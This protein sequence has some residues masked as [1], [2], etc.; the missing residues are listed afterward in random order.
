[1][2]VTTFL[3]LQYACMV[4]VEYVCNDGHR[5]KDHTET[6]DY[7]ELEHECPNGA[8]YQITTQGA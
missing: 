3:M 8:I 1:M 4:V 5:I 6:I 7:T 2:Y